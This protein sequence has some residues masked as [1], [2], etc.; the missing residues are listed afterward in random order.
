[1]YK[2]LRVLCAFLQREFL[3][4]LPQIVA[5][6]LEARGVRLVL[7]D[8]KARVARIVEA[9]QL[10]LRKVEAELFQ[11]LL[12][13]LKSML[14][15]AFLTSFFN[16]L[17]DPAVEFSYQEKI[18]KDAFERERAPLEQETRRMVEEENL[19]NPRSID[20][21]ILTKLNQVCREL[22]CA[23]TSVMKRFISSYVSTLYAEF[24]GH[25]KNF[26]LIKQ[27]KVQVLLFYEF[28]FLI[29]MVSFP[30]NFVND[31]GYNKVR[32]V[33]A[34]LSEERID[35]QRLFSVY[36]LKLKTTHTRYHY[37]FNFRSVMGNGKA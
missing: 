9:N 2:A 12:T 21:A 27:R 11:L 5:G 19:I 29:S 22:F 1:M 24:R 37:I 4:L 10:F 18:D 6:E 7:E 16:E 31:D 28:E 14:N 17:M 26:D 23:D 20:I 25:L 8:E 35:K 13:E 15:L 34:G 30:E 3:D 36:K 32:A 33:F